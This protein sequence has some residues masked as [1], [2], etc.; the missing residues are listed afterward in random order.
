MSL[1]FIFADLACCLVINVSILVIVLH[2]I[3]L[4]FLNTIVYRP[5]LMELTQI[6]KI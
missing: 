2:A 5:V 4:F 6:N 1:I 3:L